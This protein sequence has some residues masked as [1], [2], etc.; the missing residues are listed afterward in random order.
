[1][2]THQDV[3]V[4]PLSDREIDRKLQASLLVGDI[5]ERLYQAR[6]LYLGGGLLPWGVLSPAQREDYR[7]E[8]E[9]LIKGV[10]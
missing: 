7:R 6:N 5:A 4:F 9:E 10:L 1:M 3:I 8:V 2:P